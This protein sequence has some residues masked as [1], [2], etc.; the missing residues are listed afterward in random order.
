MVSHP[1]RLMRPISTLR[2]ISSLFVRGS[3]RLRAQPRISGTASH[4]RH[5]I[6]G[7]ASQKQRRLKSSRRLQE[8]FPDLVIVP[9]RRLDG[10]KR[11]LAGHGYGYGL[12]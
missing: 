11:G 9:D 8:K 3:S 7:K 10:P 4:Q 12:S 6:S 1:S 2:L 5:R